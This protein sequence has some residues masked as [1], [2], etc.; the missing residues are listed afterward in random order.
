MRGHSKWHN[1]KGNK[2]NY[3]IEEQKIRNKER[4][5]EDIKLNIKRKCSMCGEYKKVNEFK[6][7]NTKYRKNGHYN[8]YCKNCQKLYMKEYMRIYREKKRK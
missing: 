4:V 1:M 2:M 3:N 8:A 6:M 5:E 7:I